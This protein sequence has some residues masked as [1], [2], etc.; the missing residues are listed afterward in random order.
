VSA[1]PPS[2]PP[3]TTLKVAVPAPLR[4]LFDY[5]PGALDTNTL[6]AGQCL[7]VP[8]GRR[9]LTGV[10]IEVCEEATR[11]DGPALKAVIE[12]LEDDALLPPGLLELGTWAA[13]YYRH[14]VGEVFAAML[15]R[16]LR[17]GKR[18]PLSAW[19]LSVRG[20]GLPAGA[21]RRAPAQARAI[22]L[23]KERER[24][25]DE[26]RAAGVSAAVLRELAHKALI[27][28]CVP[29][30]KPPSTSLREAPPVLADEQLAALEGIRR[31]PGF[32]CHLLDGI[33]GSGKTEVYLQL[34]ADT[35]AAGRQSLVL[36]PEIGL[37]PQTLA[38]FEARFEG[39]IA[40]LHSGLAD[41]ARLAAWQ[42]ARSGAAGVV[43]GTRSALFTPL[44][45][46][47][48]IIVDE[49]HDGSYKQQ[50]GFRY[51]ARDVAIKRAQLEDTPVVLGSATPSLE[52]LQN[53][54]I[55]RYAHHRLRQRRGAGRLPT[56]TTID[57]RGLPL[58]AGIS[59]PLLL[60]IREAVLIEKRQA[61]LFLNRRGYAP[62]LQCHDCGWV[63]ECEHC[64]A[65][66][67]VHLGRRRLRCHHCGAG[68]AL[69]LQCP[70]C[71]S[72]QLLAQGLGTEQTEAF[73]KARL[74][75]PVHRIDSDAMRGHD[76]MRELLR[77][78]QDGE[79]CVILGTQM[80]TKGHHFPGV[81][82]VGIID[83]DALLFS[84]DFRGEERMA[85]LITQ[86]AGRAGREHAGARVLVQTHHPDRELFT[87]LSS[88]S[89]EDIAQN[90]LEQRRA[91]A[92]PPAGQLVILRAD[93]PGER[94]GERFLTELREAMGDPPGDC[95]LIGPLPAT[96]SRRAGRFRWQLLALGP[97]RT[98][99]QQLCDRFL[100]AAEGL[101]APRHLNWF[102]DV[103]PIDV[104]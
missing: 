26:L 38:R 17:L 33:T 6:A 46:P 83:A 37:T 63:G 67:T 4:R 65:R 43:I 54:R 61:L 51:N 1:A 36:I 53:A 91:T 14:P 80:L 94:D 25:N 95:R 20:H 3:S 40:V 66:L 23:L 64:T 22:A 7:R 42:A 49:E 75:C 16:A 13:A 32:A 74:P 100:Q 90:L 79:P 30:P 10:L 92:L 39:P 98:R 9:E 21:L 48:L 15:P 101:R 85:Q 11:A 34:I 99:I 35:L 29:G 70:E 55:G 93:A 8:F 56:L 24:D 12:R 28:R 96:L 104:V 5:L 97:S 31:S 27:E 89:Y 57:L 82:L 73:L 59:E 76:A 87:A 81:Q 69:P 72:R 18:L 62:T 84:A 78:G 45:R 52:S 50:D 102:L 86:V 19:R 44:A 58:Q 88:G 2:T 68:R 60:A 77:I 41:G 71:G 47:G 103:D